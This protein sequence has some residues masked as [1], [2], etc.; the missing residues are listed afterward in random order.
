LVVESLVRAASE[1]DSVVVQKADEMRVS[2]GF[3]RKVREN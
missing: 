1:V 2:R 3:T